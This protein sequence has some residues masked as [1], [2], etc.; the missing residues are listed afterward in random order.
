MGKG[1][2]KSTVRKLM[3]YAKYGRKPEAYANTHSLVLRVESLLGHK[4]NL[5]TVVR[6]RR[7]IWAEGIL[8]R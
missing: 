6:R 1:I 5:E 8:W 3:G 7:E 4:V 2:V